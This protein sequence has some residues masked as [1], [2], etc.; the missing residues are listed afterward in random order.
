MSTNLYIFAQR[1]IEVVKTGSRQTQREEYRDVW[2]TPTRNTEKIMQA[3]DK[4]Q[5]YIDWVLSTSK[6]EFVNTYAYEDVF[7]DNPI[8]TK[9]YNSGKEHLIDFI[10]WCNYMEKDGYEIKFAA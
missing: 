6:D 3:E 2:Q 1:E 7:C 4:K 10:A 8:G 9:V 5:A